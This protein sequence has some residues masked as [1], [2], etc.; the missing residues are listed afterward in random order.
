MESF[1]SL[2]CGGNLYVLLEEERLS[3]EAFA[4]AIYKVKATSILA[5]AT[6]FVRQVAT[7]L[8][9]EDIYK[10][11]SLKRIAIGGE[12]LPVEVIKLW[13]ERIGTNVEIHIHRQNVQ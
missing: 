2:F 9:E 3:V 11:A 6:I 1:A 8:A 4:H 10:L 13:R 5:L 12:M 7:Y